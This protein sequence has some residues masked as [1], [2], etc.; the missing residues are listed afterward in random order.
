MQGAVE[1][2]HTGNRVQ[3]KMSSAQMETFC[4]AQRD[5]MYFQIR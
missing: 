1:E 2:L 5:T 4:I 3:A